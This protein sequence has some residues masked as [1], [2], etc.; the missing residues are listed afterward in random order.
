MPCPSIDVGRDAKWAAAVI[1][2]AVLVLSI[3]AVAFVLDQQDQEGTPDRDTV[4]GGPTAS[5]TIYREGSETRSESNISDGVLFASDDSRDVIQRTI[6]MTSPGDSVLVRAG[7]YELKDAV[8]VPDG[9]TMGGE[10]PATVFIGQG[11]EAFTITERTNVT[12]ANFTLR[13]SGPIVVAGHDRPA[14]NILIKDVTAT[15]D[16]SHEGV[17]YVLSIDT[18]V[19]NVTFLRCTAIDCGTNGF[20]NNGVG[21]GWIENISYIDCSAVRCGLEERY[22][23]WIV[24]FD[25]AERVNI[26]NMTVQGCVA[27]DNWQSGFH[28]EPPAELENVVMYDCVSNNNGR[29][30]GSPDG[31]G[32]GWGYLIYDRPWHDVSLLNCTASGNYRGDTDL[33]P[34][35]PEFRTLG[36]RR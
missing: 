12:M 9:I 25:L 32:Y 31:N 4:H 20:I 1:I 5:Y 18:V 30:E 16:T 15:V 13:G 7:E 3:V 26:R 22:N 23:D 6:D 34:L 36:A 8:A 35:T 28:F 11:M 33:G 17:F 29:S 19:S 14:S 24:G 2:A 27:N 21:R 10:G